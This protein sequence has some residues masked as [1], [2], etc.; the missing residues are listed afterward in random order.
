M[1]AV[2]LLVTFLQVKWSFPNAFFKILKSIIKDRLEKQPKKTQKATTE[3]YP[4]NSQH[5]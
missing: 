5:S 3:K 4:A 2:N 1:N